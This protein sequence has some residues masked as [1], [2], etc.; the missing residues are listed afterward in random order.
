LHYFTLDIIWE[1]A[2]GKVLG[3]VINDK[4][5][6]SLMATFKSALP[7]FALTGVYPRVFQV[8]AS[9]MFNWLLP[10]SKDPSGLGKVMG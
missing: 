10:S 5:N 3:D 9:P 4:D 7:I 1:V 2:F 6:N 8:L